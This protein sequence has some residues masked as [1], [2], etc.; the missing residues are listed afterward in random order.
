MLPTAVAAC[1]L[2]PFAAVAYWRLPFVDLGTIVGTI[3]IDLS[4]GKILG[5]V[6]VSLR[7]KSLPKGSNEIRSFGKV[8]GGKSNEIWP[9]GKTTAGK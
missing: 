6:K 1:L 2:L 3:P 7:P 9:L 4:E 5:I 8:I